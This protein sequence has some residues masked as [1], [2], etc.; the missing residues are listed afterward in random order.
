[1]LGDGGYQRAPFLAY[2]IATSHERVGSFQTE[3]VHDFMKA[4]ADE[5]GMNL[6]VHMH[7]GRNPHHVIEAAFKAL[8]RAMDE[9]TSREPRLG[10]G[11]PLSTKGT[12]S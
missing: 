11:G 10:A 1:M 5:T 6:H 2:D 12:L 3:L 7:S 9:A 4:L 8:A